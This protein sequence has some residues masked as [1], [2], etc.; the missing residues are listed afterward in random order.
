[1][2]LLNF[3]LASDMLTPP[4]NAEGAA[5]TDTLTLSIDS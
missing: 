1:M 3:A 2:V 5:V 4:L